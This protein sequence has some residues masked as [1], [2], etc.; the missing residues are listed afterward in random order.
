MYI[1]HLAVLIRRAICVDECEYAVW[2]R[3]YP[4]GGV[5]KVSLASMYIYDKPPP[6]YAVLGGGVVYYLAMSVAGSG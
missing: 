5:V 1:G 6:R 3:Y 2:Y 4:R